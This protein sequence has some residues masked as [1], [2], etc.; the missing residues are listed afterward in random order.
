M[1]DLKRPVQP[2]P[3]GV[4]AAL[5]K[6]GLTAAY[7]ARPAYQRNDYLGWIAQAK[8]DETKAKRLAQMLDELDRGGVYMNMPWHG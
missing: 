4:R 7:E 2:M 6:R 1:T 3:S 5:E 8:R